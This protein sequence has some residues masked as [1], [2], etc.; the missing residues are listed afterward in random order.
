MRAGCGSPH[1]FALLIAAALLAAWPAAAQTNTEVQWSRDVER[2]VARARSTRRPLM[3]WVLGRSASRDDDLE[4][5]QKRAFQDRLVAEISSRF[6]PVKLSRSRY[7]QVLEQWGLPANANLEIVF[8]TPDGE[9]IDRLAP[10]GAA[11]P[12]ALARKM[13]LV[14]QHYRG[15]LYERELKAKLTD[16]QTPEAEIEAALDVINELLILGADADVAAL[17]AREGLGAGLRQAAYDTLAVLSTRTSVAA[18]LQRAAID[19]AAAAALGTCTPE[20][21]EWMLAEFSADDPRL[22]LVVYHAVTRICRVPDPKADRF[23][24]GRYERLKL[25]ELERVSRAVEAAARRWRERYAE[26]R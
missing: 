10:S 19:E 6:V 20:A 26:C 1:R 23:W 5:D 12:D 25:D 11:A 4:R 9:V 15:V 21:A 24:A 22:R 14:F 18:L 8:T 3:F 2:S 13:T 7:R 17:P 16:A